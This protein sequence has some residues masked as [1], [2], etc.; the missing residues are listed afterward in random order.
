MND[1]AEFDKQ[2]QEYVAHF[3]SQF[4]PEMMR[5]VKEQVFADSQYIFFWN[6]RG[7]QYGYGTCCET[8]FETPVRLKHKET[9]FC[10][11]CGRYCVSRYAN[12]GHKKLTVNAYFVFYEK[13]QINPQ[14]IVARGIYAII[15]YTKGFRNVVPSLN[16]EAY[17]VFEPGKPVMITK[18]S[19]YDY[20]KKGMYRSWAVWELTKTVHS[21]FPVFTTT[22]FGTYSKTIRDYSH[23]SIVAAVQG[24]PYQ[25]SGWENYQHDD[26]VRFFSLFSDYPCI[27]YLTKLGFDGVVEAKLKGM[28]TFSVVNWRGKSLARVLRVPLTSRELREIRGI[29][30]SVDP[31]FLYILQLSIKEGR[32]LSIRDV[33]ELSSAVRGYIDPLKKMLAY[34]T[35][36]K[37]YVY[38]QKQYLKQGKKKENYNS[39]NTV[40]TDWRDYLNEC[41]EL[42]LDVKNDYVL[43]PPSLHLA[44]ENTTKQIKVKKN[45]AHKKAIIKRA[46]ELQRYCYE[47]D[48]LL[49][50]PIGS[51][52]EMVNEGQKLRHCVANYIEGYAT[53]RY[54]LL[55]IRKIECPSEPY[56]TMEIRQGKIIQIRGKRNCAAT[57]EID[58]FIDG[59]L[60]ERVDKKAPRIRVTA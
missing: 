10:P 59:F 44:H 20:S 26:M 22:R 6:I 14:A 12:Y 37:A 48:G 50:R 36:Q 60:F 35:L 46:K 24:T 30:G 51:I 41:K 52:E 5:Y 21:L 32:S 55:V 11:V 17:Y 38:A 25:Y 29:A 43:F 2:A 53:G 33:D 27:E 45:S 15:D 9:V 13:S 47:C 54:D 3:S 39:L 4:S 1:L 8:E 19:Y 57:P 40:L 34:T 18:R 56:Y 49:I 42:S 16:V 28:H 58:N 31:T 7:K 23:E